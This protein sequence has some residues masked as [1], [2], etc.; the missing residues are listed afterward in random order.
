[1]INFLK[2]NLIG[3]KFIRSNGDISP[4]ILDIKM[5]T[6]SIPDSPENDWWGYTYQEATVYFNSPWGE[7]SE[8]PLKECLNLRLEGE[9]GF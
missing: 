4:T 6:I 3:K 5:K 1:M 8:I 2:N 7:K 9:P